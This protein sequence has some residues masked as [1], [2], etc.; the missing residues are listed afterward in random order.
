MTLAELNAG[1]EN[2]LN[3][4]VFGLLLTRLV[5]AEAWANVN[6]PI[7]TFKAS[8]GD[9]LRLN[10]GPMCSRMV[11][12]QYTKAVAEEFENCLKRAAVREGHELLLLYCEQTNQFQVYKAQPW[13]QFARIIRNV[14]SHKD[15]GMLREWP[16]DLKRAG[17]SSV[18]WHQHVLAESMVGS[19]VA[20][21]LYDALNL[22]KDQIDFARTK[23]A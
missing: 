21:T 11:I 3:N 20:F 1:I 9:L 17:I 18:F 10:V 23:L 14:V 4:I 6:P 15:A 7:A 16:S 8:L 19:A 13:F 12:P 22:L 2:V 5:P